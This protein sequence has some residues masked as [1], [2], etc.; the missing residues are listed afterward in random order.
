MTLKYRQLICLFHIDG[1]LDIHHLML[2]VLFNYYTR[3]CLSSSAPRPCSDGDTA[4]GKSSAG[5]DCLDTF[6]LTISHKNRSV[7]NV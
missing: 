1:P 4:A 3:F 6:S 2:L 5:I 7:R